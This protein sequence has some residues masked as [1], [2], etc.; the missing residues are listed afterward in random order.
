LAATPFALNLHNFQDTQFY[1]GRLE[2]SVDSGPWEDVVAAGG[3]HLLPGED[4][5]FRQPG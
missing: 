5:S 2:K 3:H 1:G 4:T